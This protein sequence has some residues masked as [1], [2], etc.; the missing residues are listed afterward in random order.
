M[1]EIRKKCLN[2][3]Y[4]ENGEDCDY[5]Q[6][7]VKY[8]NGKFCNEYWA[9]EKPSACGFSIIDKDNFDKQGHQI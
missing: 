2:C 7:K 8:I 9:K 6:E 4:C 1:G 3:R 5:R